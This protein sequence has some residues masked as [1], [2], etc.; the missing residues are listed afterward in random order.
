MSTPLQ[1]LPQGIPLT[2][3]TLSYEQLAHTIDHSLL[4]PE[5]TEGEIRAGCDLARR[6]A[7]ASVCVKPCDV[8]LAVHLLSGSAV[9]VG[10]VIGFPHG[11][12]ATAT[13][14]FEARQAVADG[15]T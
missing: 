9:R 1:T 12:A 6:Y 14:V 10:T 7:V 8:P 5:L 13:K 15:A 2:V 3:A 11:S 4:R